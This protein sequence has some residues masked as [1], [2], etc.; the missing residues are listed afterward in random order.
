MFPALMGILRCICLRWV[1][2]VGPY[3]EKLSFNTIV[4]T[5]THVLSDST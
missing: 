3:K 2:L 1:G 4:R 5:G